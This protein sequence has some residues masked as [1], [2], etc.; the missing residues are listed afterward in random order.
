MNKTG[1]GEGLAEGG[2]G[3]VGDSRHGDRCALAWAGGRV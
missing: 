1:L 3:G 2:A